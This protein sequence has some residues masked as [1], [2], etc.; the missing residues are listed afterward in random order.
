[1]QLEPNLNAKV[2]LTVSGYY[3]DILEHYYQVT[4]SN[5]LV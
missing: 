1:M 2:N 5:Q 4:H 3:N